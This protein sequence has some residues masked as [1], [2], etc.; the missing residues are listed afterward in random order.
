MSKYGHNRTTHTCDAESKQNAFH[1][2]TM[3]RNALFFFVKSSPF[4]RKTMYI[5]NNNA[6]PLSNTIIVHSV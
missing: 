6:N 3:A 4:Q 1:K 5:C 2:Q